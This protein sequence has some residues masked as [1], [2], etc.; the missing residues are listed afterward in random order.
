MHSI[1]FFVELILG[2][3]K[4]FW[5]LSRIEFTGPV[6]AVFPVVCSNHGIADGTQ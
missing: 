2:E 6:K 1:G 5:S 4:L 3:L